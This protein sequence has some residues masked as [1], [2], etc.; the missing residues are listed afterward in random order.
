MSLIQEFDEIYDE[1]FKDEHD[2][3]PRLVHSQIT[4]NLWIGG[5]NEGFKFLNS[6]YEDY[7]DVV[8]NLYKPSD[9]PNHKNLCFEDSDISEVD[10]VKL[11]E[12][13]L[14][15]FNNITS[16]K[17]VL[18]RC[19][20]GLNRSALVCSLVLMKLGFDART[21]IKIIRSKR[22]NLVLYNKSY[23][24]WLLQNGKRFVI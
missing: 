6:S 9:K 23:E 17:K 20:V 4:N 19:Q 16:D 15:I 2:E 5:T 12:F 13:V 24:D 8:Y 11:K 18:V 22:S 7:F 3:F 1:R 10:L 21:A 14:D